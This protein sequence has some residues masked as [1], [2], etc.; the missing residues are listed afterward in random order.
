MTEKIAALLS[1]CRLLAMDPEFVWLD[2]GLLGQIE[3]RWQL[4]L[5]DAG[6]DASDLLDD[7][8]T[9]AEHVDRVAGTLRQVAGEKQA[10]EVELERKGEDLA[11]AKTV[12]ER[13]NLEQ[14]RRETQKDL[15]DLDEQMTA[16][17]DELLAAGSPFGAAF[18]YA[19]DYRALLHSAPEHEPKPDPVVGIE[20]GEPQ[21]DTPIEPST[22]PTTEAIR[23][24]AST[25]ENVPG[26]ASETELPAPSQLVPRDQMQKQ[27]PVQ[28]DP[29]PVTTSQT[30]PASPSTLE[31]EV[32]NARAG[33]V[34]Q[35]LTF[36]QLSEILRHDNTITAIAGT[37][38]AD[39]EELAGCL[40]T[41]V[42]QSGTG[43]F[44]TIDD[45]GDR[46]AFASRLK[47]LVGNRDKKGHTVIVV[48][49]SVPWTGVWVGEA[50]E[51]LN[52]LKSPTGYVALCFIA[53]PNTLWGTLSD[54]RLNE[55]GIP[56]IS[57]LPWREV[58]IRQY[59]EDLQLS[60]TTD[61]IRDATGFWPALLYPLV[62]NCTQ[63][64]DLQ[65]RANAAI[66]KLKDS[67]AAKQLFAKFGLNVAVAV[68]ILSTLAELGQ[69]SEPACVPCEA[70]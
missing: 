66:E 62:D 41:F 33:N 6:D 16:R 9:A 36:Q 42:E 45:V 52:R 13:R 44:D 17:Q 37:A 20:P 51:I 19:T 2:A 23:P 12:V 3:A 64:S 21:C 38:A 59:L 50:K 68:P 61:A 48:P 14:K 31:D 8:G 4:A 56:W 15:L 53:D 55:L 69:A 49:S 60:T 46:Q 43:A 11:S 67:H 58:F 47:N 28:A 70:M 22:Q 27:L 35:P 1:Q 40:K 26:N 32:Y 25:E 7:A 5:A 24:V 54:D 30:N 65:R 39:I 57:L 34:C 18:D 10:V 63:V 29:T